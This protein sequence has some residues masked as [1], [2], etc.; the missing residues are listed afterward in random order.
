MIA[1]SYRLTAQAKQDLREIW[2]YIAQDKISAADKVLSSFFEVFSQLS[3]FP[4]LGHR[5]NDLTI[6][7]LHF[8][9]VGNY[10]VVYRSKTEPL[11]IYRVLSRYR[12]IA[13]QLN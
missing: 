11:E 8:F 13:Q 12:D 9:S 6:E 3:G 7:N 1:T 5:R 10:M 2:A 4:N